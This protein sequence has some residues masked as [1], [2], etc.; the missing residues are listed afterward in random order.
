V[1]AAGFVRML[2]ATLG[3]LML[4]MLRGLADDL[5]VLVRLKWRSASGGP[6]WRR[7]R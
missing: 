1:I 2:A 3:R 5:L 4:A 7:W 6:R